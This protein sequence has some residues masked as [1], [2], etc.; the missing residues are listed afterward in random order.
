MEII[1]NPVKYFK[2]FFKKRCKIIASK[3]K[4]EDRYISATSHDCALGYLLVFYDILWVNLMLLEDDKNRR[5][6]QAVHA[7]VVK[8]VAL[9]RSGWRAKVSHVPLNVVSN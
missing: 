7:A 8:A 2:G 5:V 4:K 3:G 9:I 1:K 6:Q